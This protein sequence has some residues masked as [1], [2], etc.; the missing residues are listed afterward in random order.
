MDLCQTAGCERP[1]FINWR[2]LLGLDYDILSSMPK[3]PA[4]LRLEHFS[5]TILLHL[6]ICVQKPVDLLCWISGLRVRSKIYYHCF[7]TFL[8]LFFTSGYIP[9][10][11]LQ[12]MLLD[13]LDFV[14]V[15]TLGLCS[16]WPSDRA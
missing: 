13:K 4:V 5:N 15:A 1:Q 16:P 11:S 2:E 7:L 8:S 10:I 6:K 9:S 3:E 12:Y 14:V